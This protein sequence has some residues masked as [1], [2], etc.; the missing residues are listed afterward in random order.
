[1]TDRIHAL[2]VALA[3]DVRDDDV[4]PLLNAILQLRG[5]VGVTPLVVEAT[6]YVAR[7]RVQTEWRQKV[8]ALFEATP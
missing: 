3:I 4:Q 6:D 1:M 5:V 8:V 2:T 7:Q